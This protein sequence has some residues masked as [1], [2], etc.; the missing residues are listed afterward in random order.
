MNIL[1]CAIFFMANAAYAREQTNPPQSSQAAPATTREVRFKKKINAGI[2]QAELRKAGFS[3][4]YIQCSTDNCTIV[5]PVAETKDPLPIVQKHIY[6]DLTE[7]RKKKYA[8]LGAL[9]DK[10]EAGT[11]TSAEKDDLIRQ[12]IGLMLGR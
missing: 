8:A 7:A 5:M 9:Y 1:M 4:N 2:L 3:V 11:I 6:T 12:A 10:W